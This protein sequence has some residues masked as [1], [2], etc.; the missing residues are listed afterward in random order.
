MSNE[1]ENDNL[2][3]APGTNPEPVVI[4]SRQ[5]MFGASD[6]GDTSGYGGLVA[7]VLFPAAAVRPYGGYYDEVADHLE[8]ALV[9]GSASYAQAV[10]RV[11]IDRG[12]MTVFVAREHLLAVARA[13]R[14]DPALR[15]EMCTGVSGVHY[16]HDTGRELHAVYHLRSITNGGGVIRHEVTCPDDD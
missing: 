7:P 4:G 12:E 15:F 2:P 16:P 3:A 11:V 8:R 5:G 6:G 13:L 1:G 9:G 10:E 14:D